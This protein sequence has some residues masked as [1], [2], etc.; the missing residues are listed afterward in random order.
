MLLLRPTRVFLIPAISIRRTSVVF[1]MLLCNKLRS[2]AFSAS[3][4]PVGRGSRMLFPRHRNGNA[5]SI[6]EKELKIAKRCAAR[7]EQFL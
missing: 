1:V 7:S 6:S 4:E 3:S 5:R 2:L